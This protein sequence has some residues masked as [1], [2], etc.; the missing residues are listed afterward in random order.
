MA[1]ASVQGSLPS[2]YNRDLQVTKGI[3]IRS[4]ERALDVL[5]VIRRTVEAMQIDR[6][7]CREACDDAILATDQ[8]TLL[9]ISGVPFR[10][11]YREIKQGG[12][13]PALTMEQAI[14]R[15]RSEG[16]PGNLQL[17]GLDIRIN[18]QAFLRIFGR[19]NRRRQHLLDPRW[20]MGR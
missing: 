18:Q 16:N 15:K 14:R 11:A 9:A 10:D 7:R 8:A 19:R 13:G 1:M 6:K 2:G 12:S 5:E 3:L 17:K 4:V 20:R